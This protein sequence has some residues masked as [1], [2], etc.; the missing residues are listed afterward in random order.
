MLSVWPEQ[1]D[2]VAAF[3]REAGAEA[4]LEELAGGGATAAEAAE[5]IGCELRQIVKSLVFVC[6]GLPVIVLVPGDRRAEGAKV[7]LGAR[8]GSARIARPDEVAAATGFEPGSVAP[9]PTGGRRVIVEQTLLT[10]S[11]VWA[12]AGST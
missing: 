3:L 10:E 4:R 6:D 9:F 5:T 2:R 1:V 7:A 12:G 11:L 8:A